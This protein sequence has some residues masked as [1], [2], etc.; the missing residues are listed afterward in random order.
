ML[1]SI[2]QKNN[3]MV[4][5]EIFLA[6]ESNISGSGVLRNMSQPHGKPKPTSGHVKH[7]IN[8]TA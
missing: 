2:E 3:A 7:D 1:L 8:E 6:L 4:L 5:G